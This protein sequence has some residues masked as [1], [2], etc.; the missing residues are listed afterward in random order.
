MIVNQV[1]TSAK[2]RG[3]TGHVKRWTVVA[4]KKAFGAQR[5]MDPEAT[6]RSKTRVVKVTPVNHDPMGPEKSTSAS[7]FQ[8]TSEDQPRVVWGFHILQPTCKPLA[9]Q[10]EPLQLNSNTATQ[11]KSYESN[12]YMATASL[13]SLQWWGCASHFVSTKRRPSRTSLP[14]TGSHTNISRQN[15]LTFKG[16]KYHGLTHKVHHYKL[17]SLSHFKNVDVFVWR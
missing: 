11:S 5:G 16:R 3:A 1:P 13:F 6:V 17:G 7:A 15:A 9:A 8:H 14:N 12:L 2:P 10:K 4:E